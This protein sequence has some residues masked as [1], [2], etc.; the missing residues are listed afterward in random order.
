[1]EFQFGTNWSRF[2]RFA[3]GVIGQTLAM[4][5]MFAFFL[6]SSFLGLF[7]FGEK[8]LSPR[9]HLAAAF[10]VFAGSWLSGYF[11]VA[12]DAWM[13]HPVGYTVA[14]DGSRSAGQPVGAAAEPLGILAIPAHD[15]RRAGHRRVRDGGP[16]RVLRAARPRRRRSRGVGGAA[17]DRRGRGGA[18]QRLAAVP[19]RRPPGGAGRR[20]SARHAGGD[21]GAVCRRQNA[22]AAGPGRPAE[23]RRAA[24]RQ[25]A[26]GARRAQLPD[27][28]ALDRVGAAGWIG[29]PPTRG[30]TTSACSITA[31]T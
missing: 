6:E 26:G 5:G 2:S 16:G 13:Q 18:G 15:G 11:I 27:P 21:G 8:R 19:Q 14:P 1:M 31:T 23:R 4:E 22:R 12:T 30:P 20:E 3:G 7:L 10:A 17:E 24:H 29:S 9:A 25:H 28:P